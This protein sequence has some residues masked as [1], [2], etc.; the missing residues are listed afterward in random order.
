MPVTPDAYRNRLHALIFSPECASRLGAVQTTLLWKFVWLHADELSDSSVDEARRDSL[1][2]IGEILERMV[3]LPRNT[4]A[5]DEA[6]DSIMAKVDA[7]DTRARHHSQWKPSPAFRR[8]YDRL[9]TGT[10]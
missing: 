6:V 10:D 2:S 3:A 9:D 1:I 4:R 8:F 5:L 7:L